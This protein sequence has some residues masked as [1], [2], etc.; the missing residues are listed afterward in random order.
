[1]Q[2][3]SQ[4]SVVASF[5]MLLTV[6]RDS[7]LKTMR[8]IVEAARKNP[9]AMNFGAVL[10]GSTQH[11]SA[12]LLTQ[13]ENIQADIIT[14]KST[15]DLITAMLRKEIDVGFDF[16]AGFVGSISDK[17]LRVVASA[18]E[19]RTGYLPDVPT[20]KESGYPAYIVT[21]W[22]GLSTAAGLPADVQKYLSDKIIEAL[23]DPS[24]KEKAAALGLK[25]EGT[26]PQDMR[27]RMSADV[28]RWGGV[29]EKAG[30][31]KQ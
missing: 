16:Y 4:V 30:I 17:Q 23:R 5:D 26:T 13:L 27:A 11:L 8:D 18:G 19:E 10:P 3:F 29:I 22:N 21:S 6:P 28:K 1:V 31:P 7:P 20:A 9:N 14:Y 2:D 15:P 25:A 12:V 24:V